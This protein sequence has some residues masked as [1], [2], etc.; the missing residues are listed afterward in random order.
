MNSSILSN[1]NSP[2]PA[3]SRTLKK[4]NLRDHRALQRVLAQNVIDQHH[5]QEN[6]RV[7]QHQSYLP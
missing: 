4:Q 6:Q 2:R 7:L 1:L 5:Q 3:S